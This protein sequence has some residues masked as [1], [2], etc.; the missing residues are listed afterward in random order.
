MEAY[1]ASIK[2]KTGKTPDDFKVLA[3]EKGLKVYKDIMA[4]L[5]AEFGLGHGHANL[6]A[7][8][9]AQADEP[10]LSQDESLNTHFSGAKAAWRAAFDDLYTQVSAFGL[11][12]TLGRGK[13]YV[14]LLR[15]GKKFGIVQVTAKRLDIG[16][17]LKGAPFSEKFEDSSAWNEMVTHRVKIENPAQIDADVIAWLRQAYD[18]A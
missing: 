9:V 8:L 17:K 6:I 12:V 1:L 4:W 15:K 11:D 10:A 18:N 5:K 7:H 13:T 3:R 14:N 2:A 16:I